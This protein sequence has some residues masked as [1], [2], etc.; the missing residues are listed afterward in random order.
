MASMPVH[1]WPNVDRKRYHAKPPTRLFTVL[2]AAGAVP[3]AAGR[4]RDVWS[5]GRHVTRP[6]AQFLPLPL[7]QIVQRRTGRTL[8]AHA[9]HPSTGRGRRRAEVDTLQPR[10]IGVPAHGGSKDGLTQGRRTGADIPAH[11]ARVVGLGL[12][13]GGGDLADDAVAEPGREPLD[14]R[15][16]PFPHVDVRSIGDVAVGPQRVLPCRGPAR[17]EDTWLCDQTERTLG[18]TPRCDVRLALGPPRRSSRPRAGS[19]LPGRVLPDQGT[20]PSSAQS[21][22][23]IPGP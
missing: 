8:T 3:I 15:L 23:Q 4:G 22:L 20:G 9:V 10:A 5:L 19:R 12:D 17:V 21:T 1:R 7:S 18:V 2:P 16:D 13:G 6:P 11:V 14:L